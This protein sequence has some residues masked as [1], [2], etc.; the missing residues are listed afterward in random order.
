MPTTYDWQA[1]Y[2]RLT[3]RA[4]FTLDNA[5]FEALYWAQQFALWGSMQ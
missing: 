4:A 5:H 3:I 2:D 1:E